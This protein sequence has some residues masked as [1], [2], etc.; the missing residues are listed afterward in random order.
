LTARSPPR[1][2][3]AMAHAE[4]CGPNTRAEYFQLSPIDGK[5]GTT[6]R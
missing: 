1:V 4:C 5:S 2:I 3:V 6:C